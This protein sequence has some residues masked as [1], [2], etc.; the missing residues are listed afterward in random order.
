V[1]ETKVVKC[2]GCQQEKTCSHT[3]L[4]FVEKKWLCGDCIRKALGGLCDE[5]DRKYERERLQDHAHLLMEQSRM[6]NG[7]GDRNQR[8]KTKACWRAYKAVRRKLWG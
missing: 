6:L 8:L 1:D 5:D 3:G 7:A 4:G 2:D